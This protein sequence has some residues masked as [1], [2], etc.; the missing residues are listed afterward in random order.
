M[1]PQNVC[2]IMHQS[3]RLFLT[4]GI[5]VCTLGCLGL[6]QLFASANSPNI[7]KRPIHK[8]DKKTGYTYEQPYL[9]RARLYVDRMK[10]IA[11]YLGHD[12]LIDAL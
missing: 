2:N 11:S 12:N 1:K 3:R 6:S 5:P 4:R 9:F 10:S 7:M 8:F